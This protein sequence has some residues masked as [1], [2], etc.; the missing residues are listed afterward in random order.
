MISYYGWFLLS[1]AL[2]GFRF[3][4]GREFKEFVPSDF[5]GSGGTRSEGIS[6]GLLKSERVLITVAKPDQNDELAFFGPAEIEDAAL[7]FV[8]FSDFGFVVSPFVPP[9]DDGD[10]KA[11]DAENG[12]G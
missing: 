11:E 9:D 12:D 7:W 6:Q 2:L 1:F 5:C 3:W 4:V 10:D 8:G